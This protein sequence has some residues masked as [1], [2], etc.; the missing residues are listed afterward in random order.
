LS[1]FCLLTLFS[2]FKEISRPRKY[3]LK[4]FVVCKHTFK[5]FI[6]LYHKEYLNWN[7]LIQSSYSKLR[8]N[9][10][11]LIKSTGRK[12]SIYSGMPINLV[13]FLRKIWLGN[14]L[15]LKWLRERLQGKIP[16]ILATKS[17]SEVQ[18]LS[19]THFPLH[20]LNCRPCSQGNIVAAKYNI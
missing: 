19:T 4:L 6:S 16:T 20:W 13:F 5:R 14:Y 1:S 17:R 9:L 8:V 18:L 15:N 12:L 11:K 2:Y 10:L 3:N 7:S